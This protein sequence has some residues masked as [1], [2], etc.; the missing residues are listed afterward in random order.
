M[1]FQF[2][3]WII[4]LLLIQIQ[5][6]AQ[7]SVARQWNEMQLATIRQDFARPPVQARNLFHVSIAMYDAW[8]AYDQVAST[9]ILGKTV[10]GQAN[11]WTGEKPLIGNDTAA[12][13]N[14]AVSYAAYRV[15]KHRYGN[16]ALPGPALA[17]FD[18][19]MNVL[20]YD[21]NYTDANYATGTP[22]DL[23]NYIANRVILNG[24]Y[25]NAKEAQNYAYLEYQTLNDPLKIDTPGNP[26][27]SFPNSWQRLD[28]PGAVDQNNN[29]I[30]SVQ[31]HL[32]PEWGRVTPF[33]MTPAQSIVYFKNGGLFPVYFNPGQPPRLNLTGVNDS[34]DQ[35]F[36]WGHTM[37]SIWS[38]HLD[39]ADTTMM[40][41]SPASRG[42]GQYYPSGFQDQMNYFYKYLNG[43]DSSK[44]YSLN[45]VT[46]LPYTP[47]M[48]KRGDYTRVI[49]Q[50][51]ADG[52]TSETPPGHWYVLLNEVS[53]HP[54]FEKRYEGNGSVLDPL[55][56]DVKA[57][58]EL[59]G[60]VHDAAIA[61]WGCK[62]WYDSP[63]PISAI[64]FMADRGQSTDAG[65][66]NYHPQG[67]PLVPGYIEL[68]QPG[69]S[70]AGASNEHV[71]KIKLFTWKGFSYIQNPNTDV[72]GCGWI[73]AENWVPYQRKSF[74]TPPFAGYVS[75][76]S[77]F[78]RS[79]AELLIHLT[80]T[81]YFPGGMTEH[82]IGANS[83]YLVIEKGPSTNVPMQWA[84]YLDASD[85]SSLSRIW[86]GI[87]PPF[88][89]I[90]GRLMGVQA[91]TQAHFT[92]KGYFMGTPLPVDLSH[93]YASENQC[94]VKLEWMTEQEKNSAS[95]EIWKSTDGLKYEHWKTV[96]AAGNSESPR[97][98]QLVDKDIA[99]QNFY[100][101][102]QTDLD[103][104][105]MKLSTAAANALRCF[106]TEST[107]IQEVYPNP[108]RDVFR[109]QI[110]TREFQPG[111]RFEIFTLDGAR[112]FERNLNL[113]EGLNI[114]EYDLPKLQV[115]IY[116]LSIQVA[117]GTKSVQ[118]LQ[119]Q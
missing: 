100:Q 10:N 114:V 20:G 53:D 37:V 101:L 99:K 46:G 76:H 18:S 32:G 41:I 34:L 113:M 65:L 30:P 61:A 39:P 42:N 54:L 69:D 36:K 89:D 98:Y 77:T 109:V 22:A 63:R 118:R 107:L 91:G 29:P 110:E 45:P 48:M 50:Y 60:A 67:I 47:V 56:W 102:Y 7:H 88:D 27:M 38:S 93:F 26:T 31:K 19:L 83:G 85:E 115:G 8:A 68:I 40:D 90:K 111:T 25:D 70:L 112:V 71:N 13:R 78:S 2:L 51:W 94:Q 58:F 43:G 66:P 80:G 59:G 1:K 23:G 12:S 21:I 81:P 52:P 62:G 55:E 57:Y 119:I 96:K 28:I 103:G 17:R 117:D 11:P 116:L 16:S 9:Y 33:G 74:V 44:G 64:R 24:Y 35:L 5:S 6:Q 73:R 72:S 95:F 87:H 4:F 92:A 79:A 82:T 106:S 104:K 15:L 84:T 49:T 86:G 105:K 108:T 75:G 97:Q 14:M 3:P